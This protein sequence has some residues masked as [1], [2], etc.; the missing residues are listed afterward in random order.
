M[1]AA[2]AVSAANRQKINDIFNQFAGRVATEA[3]IAQYGAALQNGTAATAVSGQIAA[4][5]E[6]TAYRQNLIWET[7]RGFV[8]REPTQADFDYW[9]PKLANGEATPEQFRLHIANDKEPR[10]NQEYLWSTLTPDQQQ[11]Y[12]DAINKAYQDGVKRSATTE[13]I[14]MHAAALHNGIVSLTDV[15][16]DIRWSPE[17]R[18]ANGDYIPPAFTATP[19]AAGSGTAPSN[20]GSPA[21][22]A[23]TSSST[24][25]TNGKPFELVIGDSTANLGTTQLKGNGLAVYAVFADGTKL[26]V[27]A[28]MAEQLVAN[29][30]WTTPKKID[31]ATLDAVPPAGTLAS[32][33]GGIAPLEIQFD[34]SASSTKN[35]STPPP[36]ETMAGAGGVAT[37]ASVNS[38]A[39]TGT[40]T[41]EELW[42]GQSQMQD[43]NDPK[44]GYTDSQ[45]E[46]IRNYIWNGGTWQAL[47]DDALAYDGGQ[48]N[49][50][51]YVTPPDTSQA[52]SDPSKG[53]TDPVTTTPPA[54]AEPAPAATAPASWTPDIQYDKTGIAWDMN[55]P[56]YNFTEAHKQA[57]REYLFAGGTWAQYEVGYHL[58]LAGDTVGLANWE[59][60]NQIGQYSTNTQW[61]ATYQNV[62]SQGYSP[63][64]A[65]AWANG[66]YAPNLDASK[67]AAGGSAVPQNP[68]GIM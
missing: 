55:D 36:T 59:R 37:E 65:E 19:P 43:I 57:I 9:M 61:G 39:S 49:D 40:W 34:P 64:L 11:A 8:V 31:Q 56:K 28:A 20:T 41:P 66:M 30:K 3:E 6:A 35:G 68:F 32:I 18:K 24:D 47:E 26:H 52:P 33:N 44:Y 27:T 58:A 4:L 21:S 2:S 7:Y 17:G 10:A 42:D 22:S 45:K 13:E 46:Y 53:A 23:T 63:D 1:S 12:T 54:T 51:S 48:G 62:I 38:T 25:S 14:H 5:P 50:Y 60:E 16:N 67:A 15:A 29:N